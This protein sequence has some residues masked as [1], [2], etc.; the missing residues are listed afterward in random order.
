MAAD[1]T[2]LALRIA[3][4]VEGTLTVARWR[5]TS[6][7]SRLRDACIR[8]GAPDP[9]VM[10]RA[11]DD[12]RWL[13]ERG[14]GNTSVSQFVE[15]EGAPNAGEQTYAQGVLNYLN[16]WGT[17]QITRIA[18]EAL[19]GSDYLQ[20]PEFA[21]E[22]LKGEVP[23]LIADLLHLMNT[24]F[25][26]STT[27]GI[28]AMCDDGVNIPNYAGYSRITLADLAG[29]GINA[30]GALANADFSDL[31]EQMA[32]DPRGQEADFYLGPENQYTNMWRISGSREST[33]SDIR[34]MAE[35]LANG[36]NPIDAG[37][38]LSAQGFN[39]RPFYG[40]PGFNDSSI[41]GVVARHVKI[42]N[43]RPLRL[44]PQTANGDIAA[45]VLASTR[46]TP[47]YLS[48]RHAG[49]IYALTA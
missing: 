7:L 3:P 26:G 29:A 30:A 41:V 5:N 34:Y 46:A 8:A 25:L 42:V 12:F 18:L 10:G 48:T 35:T 14:N 39:S 37:L 44:D 24:V 33:A 4:V 13:I 22:Q 2:S 49:R 6:F 28:L 43:K 17:A 11:G 1:T 47:V 9:D 16:F 31:R 20:G 38:G 19:Q 36:A 21:E 32:D 45:R 23:G 27:N 40:I 15:G